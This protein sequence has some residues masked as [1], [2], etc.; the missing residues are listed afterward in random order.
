MTDREAAAELPSGP[1]DV[2]S[3]MDLDPLE[4]DRQ[5]EQSL[6][7]TCADHAARESPFR[8][9]SRNPSDSSLE[10]SLDSGFSSDVSGRFDDAEELDYAPAQSRSP[11]VHSAKRRRSND[12]PLQPPDTVT[13]NDVPPPKETPSGSITTGYRKPFHTAN[14]KSNGSPRTLRYARQA[15]P[16]IRGRRSRFV[17]ESMNDSV[18]EK[19]PSIFM[20]DDA[21]NHAG[22]RPSGIFRF[23]KA[24]ASAFNPFGAWGSKPPAD[25]IKQTGDPLSQAEKAYAELKKSG[26]KG[27]VKGSYLQNLHAESNTPQRSWNPIPE[28][29]ENGPAGRHSRQNSGEITELAGPI[30][31]ELRKA[32]S[33]L[34]IPLVKRQDSSKFL[35][36]LEGS[37]VRRQKSRKELQRQAKL[38]KRV[39]DLEIK[40]DRARRELRALVGEEVVLAP[41]PYVERPYPRKFV[42]GALP[43]LPS[44]RLLYNEAVSPA[45]P[46]AVSAP[47]T[48][49]AESVQQG[50]PPQ[51][52]SGPHELAGTPYTTPKLP[53]ERHGQTSLSADSPSLKRKSPDPESL[54][55]TQTDSKHPTPHSDQPANFEEVTTP[56]RAKLPKMFTSD[57]PGS[58]ERKQS[59]D[60]G[61]SPSEE[62]GRRR[63]QPLRSASTRSPSGRRR[64]SNSCNRAQPSLRMKKGRADLRGTSE[65]I[66]SHGDHDKE[67]RPT[68]PTP[69]DDG[70]E[71]PQAFSSLD[72]GTSPSSTKKKPIRYEYIPPV[73]PL[74]KDLSATAAKVDRRLAKEMVKKR[75]ARNKAMAEAGVKPEGVEMINGFQWPEDFF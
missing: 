62:R 34:G 53:Q 31:S 45:S 28:R 7:S 10:S 73:P 71:E 4:A 21:R 9:H 1:V 11:S 67:N 33:S 16:S 44:E 19:P 46:R 50:A 75:E 2:N 59:K 70:S 8:K 23:G 69:P 12:W 47:L 5:L 3:A 48:S 22:Q 40:L 51:P 18:S 37:A 42:P 64:A 55:A 41:T 36:E 13:D 54:K 29:M 66:P 30:R 27:T 63:S 65:P 49:L 57:S 26:Y 56:R 74:P 35:E 61:R 72:E 24:I 20:R 68:T 32:K 39:S 15:V 6:Q 58:V 52:S 38:M 43:S 25:A 14:I 60:T 17:E